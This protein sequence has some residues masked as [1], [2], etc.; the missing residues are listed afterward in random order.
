[1]TPQSEEVLHAALSLPAKERVALAEQLLDSVQAAPEQNEID[2]AWA[3][4]IERRLR[5]YRE[6]KSQTIPAEEVFRALQNRKK[7]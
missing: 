5:A 3:A 7:T 6:G 1:M 4:E 2:R